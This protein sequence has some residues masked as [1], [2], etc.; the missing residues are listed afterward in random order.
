[1]HFVGP[2]ILKLPWDKATEMECYQNEIKPVLLVME[3]PTLDDAIAMTSSNPYGTAAAFSPR[4][5]LLPV[6]SR[7]RQARWA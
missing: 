3:A 1:M 6:H 5:A 4:R 2:T 7:G